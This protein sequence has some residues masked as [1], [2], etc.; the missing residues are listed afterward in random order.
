MFSMRDLQAGRVTEAWRA[1]VRFQIQRNR[2]LYDEAWPGIAM[3][4]SDGRFAI[5]AAAE[6]ALPRHPRRHRRSVAL[7]CFFRATPTS[8]RQQGSCV[9]QA[10]GGRPGPYTPMPRPLSLPPIPDASA[11]TPTRLGLCSPNARPPICG[12]ALCFWPP[13]QEHAGDVF[14]I[15]LP[16]FN[17]VV[18][19]G[20][21]A[22]QQSLRRQTPSILL[23][24]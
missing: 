10:F 17:M 1:F 18:L 22:G 3:L 23:A 24:H 5:A 2:Q 9:C 14:Q 13:L 6:P 12:S 21:D 20:P 8:R 16:G 7:M 15:Q 11:S 4:A 19:T